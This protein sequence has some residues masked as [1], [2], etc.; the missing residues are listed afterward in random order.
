MK[1]S[2]TN[3]NVRKTPILAFHRCITLYVPLAVLLGFFFGDK[4]FTIF[5]LHGHFKKHKTFLFAFVCTIPFSLFKKSLLVFIIS[6]R[7]YRDHTL[8]SVTV[9]LQ[10][11]LVIT[12]FASHKTNQ[13][14]YKHM[15]KN[16]LSV[17][18]A[19]VHWWVPQTYKMY[20]FLTVKSYVWYFSVF[21]PLLTEHILLFRQLRQSGDP[22]C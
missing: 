13:S 21:P 5:I 10:E 1:P 20:V 2:S 4:I 3:H 11:L 9:L 8:F 15:H 17:W 14:L 6:M 18:D 12:P 16:N 22:L 7:L 19:V